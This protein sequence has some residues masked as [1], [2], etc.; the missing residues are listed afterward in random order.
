M[1]KRVEGLGSKVLRFR[2][3]G[4]GMEPPLAS[5]DKLQKRATSRAR[6]SMSEDTISKKDSSRVQ[7]GPRRFHFKYVTD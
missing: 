5:L 3:Q 2:V 1:F 6:F 7:R 4:L